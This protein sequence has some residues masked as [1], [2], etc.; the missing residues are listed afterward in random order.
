MDKKPCTRGA[1][2]VL[3]GLSKYHR[4][5]SVAISAEEKAS[6]EAH[7]ELPGGVETRSSRWPGKA[8]WATPELTT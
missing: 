6:G 1:P 5:D 2:I 8:P 4:V 3:W 7:T